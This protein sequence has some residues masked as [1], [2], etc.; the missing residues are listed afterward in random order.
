MGGLFSADPKNTFL[1]DFL[2]K[3]REIPIPD[4]YQDVAQFD[5]VFCLTEKNLY[6]PVYN[7]NINKFIVIDKRNKYITEC[8]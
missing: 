1:Y 2:T 8:L 7:I 3:W 6:H 4:S 5:K